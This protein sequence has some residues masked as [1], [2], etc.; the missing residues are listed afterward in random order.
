MIL[1]Y[2]LETF[3]SQIAQ[4]VVSLRFGILEDNLIN[5]VVLDLGVYYGLSGIFKEC[6]L[7]RETN[8]LRK[9]TIVVNFL[10]LA[11]EY[12]ISVCQLEDEVKCAAKKLWSTAYDV[13]DYNQR[14]LELIKS[15]DRFDSIRKECAFGL[16][17][18]V[19]LS[20]REVAVTYLSEDLVRLL[21]GEF[22]TLLCL[23]LEYDSVWF[24]RFVST[25]MSET[26]WW[27]DNIFRNSMRTSMV[28]FCR[29]ARLKLMDASIALTLH[30]ETKLSGTSTEPRIFGYGPVIS[31]MWQDSELEKLRWGKQLAKDKG[32]SFV[33]TSYMSPVLGDM[34]ALLDFQKSYVEFLL[35]QWELENSGCVSLAAPPIFRDIVADSEMV[36]CLLLGLFR[37]QMQ[38]CRRRSDFMS[39]CCKLAGL[40]SSIKNLPIKELKIS[41]WHKCPW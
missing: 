5:L 25:I 35:H 7:R 33:R 27:E 13:A 24:G 30:S 1:S 29:G 34:F 31:A 9:E 11:R 12:R 22:L 39:M 38:R 28:R 10:R 8:Q 21:M 2:L 4:E 16:F 26:C 18:K 17:P 23:T 19:S 14:L 37:Y 40:G 41:P 32:Y 20:L 3:T 6:V 36:G 15:R